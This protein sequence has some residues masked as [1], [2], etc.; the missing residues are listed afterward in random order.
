MFRRYAGS[1]RLIGYLC[2][3]VTLIFAFGLACSPSR[4]VVALACPEEHW[5]AQITPDSVLT[6]CAPPD[7]VQVKHSRIWTRAP[8]GSAPPF[9]NDDLFTLYEVSAAD[10]FRDTELQPWPPS[11]LRDQETPLCP[12][13]LEVTDY[14]VHWDSVGTHLVR[15]ETGHVTGGFS[16]E[17]DKPMLQAAWMADST[18]WVIVEA[19]AR[20]D[21][22]LKALRQIL[23]TIRL[24]Q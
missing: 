8:A 21:T 23:R 9:A 16:G 15:V 10:A 22:G 11:I 13:C 18:H 7:L 4:R 2:P 1:M 17:H 12:D 24:R 19:Q 6:F 14:A 20:T 3:S 5:S